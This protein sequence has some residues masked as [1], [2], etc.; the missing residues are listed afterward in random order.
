MERGSSRMLEIK[1]LRLNRAYANISEVELVVYASWSASRHYI[2]QLNT[3]G[4]LTVT[5]TANCLAKFVIW[6]GTPTPPQL[7]W[8]PK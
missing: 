3:S 5:F 6:P 2:K 8:P 1:H 7:R 4:R